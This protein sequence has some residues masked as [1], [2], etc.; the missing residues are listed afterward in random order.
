MYKREKNQRKI[1][2]PHNCIFTSIL[3]SDHE[4]LVTTSLMLGLKRES[5]AALSL[6][7]APRYH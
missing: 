6:S 2:Y 5:V 4:K 3:F 1:A 7:Q